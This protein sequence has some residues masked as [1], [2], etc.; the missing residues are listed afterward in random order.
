M[1]LYKTSFINGKSYRKGKEYDKNGNLIFEGLWYDGYQT[2]GVRY[3]YSEEG[4]LYLEKEID[5]QYARK[6]KVYS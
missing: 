6:F 4:K 3:Y 2:K 1:I 5:D